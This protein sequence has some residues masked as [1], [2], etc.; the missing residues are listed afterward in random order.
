M[1]DH[2]IVVSEA[3]L[4][5]F[6]VVF[7]SRNAEMKV[8]IIRVRRRRSLGL[9]VTW[10]NNSSTLLRFKC[11]LFCLFA[12]TQDSEMSQRVES[13]RADV[14]SNVHLEPRA[15]NRLCFH[16]LLLLAVGWTGSYRRGCRVKTERRWESEKKHLKY[17][18]LG[19]QRLRG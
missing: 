9:C 10:L 7:G 2:W 6:V 17:A 3:I 18:G 12:P 1:L 16:T 14:H 11:A 5:C 15:P 8:Q 19:V 4:R 13:R